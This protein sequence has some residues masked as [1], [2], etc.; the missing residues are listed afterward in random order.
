MKSQICHKDMN[1]GVIASRYAKALLSYVTEDGAGEKTYSQACALVQCLSVLP[2]L[3]E[4]VLKHDDIPLE[5]KAGLLLSALGEPLADH[6][7]RFMRLVAD[8]RR[9]EF[10]DAMLWS[11]IARYREVCRI[12]VGSLVT[13]VPD[14]GLRERLEGIFHDRTSCEVR[15]RT[16][17]NPDLIGG[18]VL[19]LDGY[20]LDASVRTRLEQIRRALIDD[21]NRIV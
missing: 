12:K 17:V 19:E 18:F 20:R 4:Y 10:F 3:R 7:R 5:K 2:Q 14:D 8:H 11:F 6:L 16:E 15:F 13:P 1:S 9:M 21:T